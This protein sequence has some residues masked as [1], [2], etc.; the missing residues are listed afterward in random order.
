MEQSQKYP[1]ID[2]TKNEYYQVQRALEI[3][4][5]VVD[6]E[7]KRHE[8][9]QQL[10]LS[11]LSMLEDEIIPMLSNEMEYDDGPSDDEIGGSPQMTADEMHTAAWRQHQELHS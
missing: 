3:L 9:N 7:S 1:T 6:R 5:Q 4:Q 11:M 8:M 2:W 10:T